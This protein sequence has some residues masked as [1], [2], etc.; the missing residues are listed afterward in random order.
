MTLEATDWHAVALER[1]VKVF[2]AREADELMRA[3]NRELGIDRV[4]SAED[5]RRFSAALGKRG[6]FAAA[7]GGM[8]GL[9]AAIHDKG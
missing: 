2:G 7:V 4:R 3:V 1:L 9:H 5:L 6:G 8:L